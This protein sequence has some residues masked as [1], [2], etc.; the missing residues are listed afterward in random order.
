[1]FY[2]PHAHCGRDHACVDG[3]L[4]YTGNSS[5]DNFLHYLRSFLLSLRLVCR[6]SAVPTFRLPRT[7]EHP[8]VRPNVTLNKVHI[9]TSAALRLHCFLL[10]PGLFLFSTS[11][12]FPSFFIHFRWC[13]GSYDARTRPTCRLQIPHCVARTLAGCTDGGWVG[14]SSN[15][16][17]VSCQRR[18]PAASAR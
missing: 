13:G 11:F 5:R 9:T 17:H 10:L 12:L 18:K 4:I 14:V 15:P 6:A 3:A 2:D 16:R 1:M 8:R 7:P